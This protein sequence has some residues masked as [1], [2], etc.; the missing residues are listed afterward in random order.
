VNV[1][2]GVFFQ[3][4]V[5]LPR[6]RHELSREQVLDVQRERLM[7]AVVELMAVSGYHAV[8]VREVAARAGVSTAAFYECFPDKVS[9][10]FAA[11]DRFIQVLMERIAASVRPGEQEWGDFVVGLVDGYLGTLQRDLVVAR[12]F[13]V[14]MDAVGG[15]ARER[16]R[17]ALGAVADLVRA[18]RER[19]WSGGHA[20]LSPLA[21]IAT[22]YGVR[23]IASDAL[24]EQDHPNLLALVPV[25]ATWV[26]TTLR[27]A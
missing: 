14:E 17:Q 2:E 15:V 26:A 27:G 22:V 12:A 13:Q 10:V 16:R 4:S 18:E 7:V 9:L 11:Y 20:A 5:R 23:Q 6:G 8:T 21:Y 24:D 25:V 3:T 19:F 1:Q